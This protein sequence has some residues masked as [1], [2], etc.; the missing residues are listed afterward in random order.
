MID[1]IHYVSYI[2]QAFPLEGRVFWD[3]GFGQ[4][5]YQHLGYGM[6]VSVCNTFG[7]RDICNFAHH[8]V[9]SEFLGLGATAWLFPFCLGVR[10]TVVLAV[11][12][13]LFFMPRWS[14]VSS[15]LG[16]STLSPLFTG[17]YVSALGLALNEWPLPENLRSKFC[18]CHKKLLFSPNACER[19]M[20]LV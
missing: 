6:Q 10:Y 12:F 2:F 11:P 15:S 13:T 20:Q 16:P 14:L 17:W 7:F 18:L 9:G 8:L 5:G 4:N 3:S 1:P 19:P